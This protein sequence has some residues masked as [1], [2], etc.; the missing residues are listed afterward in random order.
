VPSS[1]L[2][3]GDEKKGEEKGEERGRIYFPDS[4]VPKNGAGLNGMDHLLFKRRHIG[5]RKGTEER[6]QIWTDQFS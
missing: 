1:A 2:P 4:A 5:G 3:G 6:G